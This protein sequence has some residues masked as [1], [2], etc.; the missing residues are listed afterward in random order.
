MKTTN[1]T[2][3]GDILLDAYNELLAHFPTIATGDSKRLRQALRTA[4]WAR[5]AYEGAAN[6][7]EAAPEGETL[8]N[9]HECEELFESARLS[10]LVQL[11]QVSLPSDEAN[12]LYAEFKLQQLP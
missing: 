7:C 4:C 10:L 5:I 1:P 12:A 11:G 6:A 9:V 2:H 3:P 8:Q